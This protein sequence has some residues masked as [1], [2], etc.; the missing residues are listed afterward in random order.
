MA[1]SSIEYEQIILNSNKAALQLLKVSDF[2]SAKTYLDTCLNILSSKY[3]PNSK[4]LLGITLNNY[5]CYY[6]RQGLLEKSLKLFHKSIQASTQAGSNVSETFLNISNVLSQN[7]NHAEA[8]QAAYN[9]I[10]SLDSNKKNTKLAVL[11][12]KAMASEFKFLGMM[13]ESQR[14]FEKAENLNLSSLRYSSKANR[15][16]MSPI[17]PQKFVRKSSFFKNGERK[18]R[19]FNRTPELEPTDR[20]F[21]DFIPAPVSFDQL[22]KKSP[23]KSTDRFRSITPKMNKSGVGSKSKG[24]YSRKLHPKCKLCLGKSVVKRNKRVEV[25]TPVP[26]KYKMQISINRSFSPLL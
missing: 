20:I 26:R 25:L 11:A 6:K 24:E 5:G 22:L 9:A 19:T 17:S 15:D 4:K 3:L 8:L 10:K 14:M 12:Y 13:K 23:V 2:P 7:S 1:E 21:V 18:F 16:T